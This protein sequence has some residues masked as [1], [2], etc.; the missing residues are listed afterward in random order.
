MEVYSDEAEPGFAQRPPYPVL[1]TIAAAGWIGFGGLAFLNVVVRLALIV[2]AGPQIRLVGPSF[3]GL[4]FGAVVVGSIGIGFV[5][6]GIRTIRGKAADTVGTSMWAF[7]FAAITWII[8]AVQVKDNL[9]IAGLTFLLGGSLIA[10]GV[11]ALVGRGTYL[12]WRKAMQ[13]RG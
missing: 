12:A 9:L 10:A 2:I 4:V 11:L 1:T 3:A 6:S 8:A 13:N 7:T 5:C